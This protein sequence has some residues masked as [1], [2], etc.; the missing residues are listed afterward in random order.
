[1]PPNILFVHVD[2][3]HHKALSA[4]GNPFVHTPCM[5]AIVAEGFSFMESTTPMPQCCPARASWFT[6]RMS[7]EHGVIV[8]EFPLNPDLPDLGQWLR[9][10]GG[11][12]CIH[13]GKWHI[14]NRDVRQGFTVPHPGH[15]HGELADADV[16]RAAAAVLRNR[17]TDKP[18]FMSVGL[19]NPHDCCYFAGAEGGIGKFGL[20]HEMLD[21]LPPLPANFATDTPIRSHRVG[22][23]SE[24]DWR[25]YIYTYYRLTEMVDR[26]VG[27]IHQAL[28]ASGFSD[29]TLFILTS[30]HGDGLGF[31][32]HIQKGYL[33]EEAWRVP[34]VVSWPGRVPAGKRDTHHLVSGIDIAATVCDYAEVE[35]LPKM[36][37]GRS[38]RPLLEG[39]HVDWRSHVIGETSVGPL[40]L[41]VREAHYK[42]VFYT[43]HAELY[44]IRYDP[45]ETK[46]VSGDP[47]HAATLARHRQHFAEYVRSIEVCSLSDWAQGR[48]PAQGDLYTPCVEWYRA[49]AEG[50]SA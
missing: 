46:D 39:R 21:R 36:T 20:A 6:G 7:K 9:D 47:V 25:Y 3:L 33:Y 8:N 4:Y 24:E 13:I 1:V 23:W 15:G 35:P 31:H 48:L 26:E 41:A 2:Q 19:L 29:N 10:K 14:P 49:M 18:F 5:D 12:D 30:D 34:A 50:A 44:D 45:L 28:R 27:R 38:W 43:D 40:A 17:D 11:Y 37:I 22:N 42:T 32:Q 16:A